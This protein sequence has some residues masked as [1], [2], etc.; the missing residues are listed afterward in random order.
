MDQKVIQYIR[1][2]WWVRILYKKYNT[3]SFVIL[4]REPEGLEFQYNKWTSVI[5][6]IQNEDPSH[7]K[8]I[9]WSV[10]NYT[11]INIFWLYRIG[12]ES[13]TFQKWIAAQ[14]SFYISTRVQ[15]IYLENSTKNGLIQKLIRKWYYTGVYQ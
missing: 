3:S 13:S 12:L 6:L 4:K 9:W 8:C 1:Y 11:G 5:F 2:M 10:Q 7:I 15:I 14:I